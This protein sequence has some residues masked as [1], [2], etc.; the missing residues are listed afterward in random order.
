MLQ[1]AVA[2]HENWRIARLRMN[3]VE[4]IVRQVDSQGIFLVFF[5]IKVFWLF[6]CSPLYFD[7]V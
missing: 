6:W 7:L 5:F 1:R 3:D 2:A 4:D